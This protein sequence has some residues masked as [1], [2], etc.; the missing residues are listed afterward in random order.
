MDM[1]DARHALLRG[2]IDHAPTFP[3]AALEALA[4]LDEDRRAVA[5]E[6]SWILAR[7]VWPAS[8]LDE[9][10]SSGRAVSAVLDAALPAGASVQAVEARYRDDMAALVGLAPEIYVEMPIDGDLELRLDQLV[11]LGLSAKVRCGG[12]DVPSPEDLARFIRACRERRL[13][14]KATAGLHHA[15]RA[16][17]EH[18]FLNVLAA[19]VFAGEED[20]ALAELDA[21]AFGLDDSGFRWR[22]RSASVEEVTSV[23]AGALRSIGSCSFFEPVEELE[24]LGMLPA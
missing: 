15:V 7:L 16:N 11:E 4:A 23:R 18:G 24:S 5:D 2:L 10:R 21:A 8:R 14:F 1:P 9:L 22:G 12:V 20:D 3:P 19:A 17:G 13:A 6:R